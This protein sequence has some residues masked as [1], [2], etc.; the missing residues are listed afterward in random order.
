MSATISP[1]KADASSL[2]IYDQQP[3]D[4]FLSRCWRR[5]QTS[6]RRTLPERTVC[7]ASCR[8]AQ[9][10]PAAL[11]GFWARPR[12]A[13]LYLQRLADTDR[14]LSRQIRELLDAGSRIWTRAVA[15]AIEQSHAASAFGADYIA[16][17]LH[18]QQWPR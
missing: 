1:I 6:R 16:N 9:R 2:A 14:S 11:G 5:G 13:E 15:A 10:C 12:L 18:Q 8:T 3:G 4:R 7:P 17:I